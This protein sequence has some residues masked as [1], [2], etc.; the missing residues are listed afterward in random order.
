MKMQ[1]EKEYR[2]MSRVIR[3]SI[4]TVTYVCIKLVKKEERK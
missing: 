3:T 2:Y 1:M 4:G